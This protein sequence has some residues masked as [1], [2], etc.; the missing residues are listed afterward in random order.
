MSFSITIFLIDSRTKST[1]QPV[2]FPLN[3]NKIYVPISLTKSWQNIRGRNSRY[4]RNRYRTLAKA[5]LG[6]TSDSY[7]YDI[8]NARIAINE[9][10]ITVLENLLK[11]V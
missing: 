3:M 1:G 10:D 6:I 8:I 11:S 2:D 7:F 5:Q 9:H 4:R